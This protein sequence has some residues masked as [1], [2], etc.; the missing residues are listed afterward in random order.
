MLLRESL[1]LEIHSKMFA[2][3]VCFKIRE[4][5]SKLVVARER[6]EGEIGYDCLMV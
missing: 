1:F 6:E 4:E 3:D 2:G 5:E